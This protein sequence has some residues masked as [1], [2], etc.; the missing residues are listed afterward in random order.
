MGVALFILKAADHSYILK[1]LNITE[2]PVTKGKHRNR[3]QLEYLQGLQVKLITVHGWF[4]EPVGQHKTVKN[5]NATESKGANRE[6][7]WHQK[8]IRKCDEN[9][10]KHFGVGCV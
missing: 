1:D 3:C 4:S 6:Q 5:V 9:N 7:N 8:S 2:A 10:Q